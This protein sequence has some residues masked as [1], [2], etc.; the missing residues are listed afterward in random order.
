LSTRAVNQVLLRK[1]MVENLKILL[2]PL[3][4]QKKIVEILSSI[5]DI[6]RLKKE[7]KEKLVKMKRRL[8]NLLLTGKVRVSV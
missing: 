5:D 6:L 3:E 8:M 1:G 2:P 4:E 7:K